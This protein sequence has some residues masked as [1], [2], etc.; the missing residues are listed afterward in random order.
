MDATHV[1]SCGPTIGLTTS[2]YVQ[3]C[4]ALQLPN[5]KSS[6]GSKGKVNFLVAAIGNPSNLKTQHT[7]VRNG[8]Q[9]L[10]CEHQPQFKYGQKWTEV[11]P[12]WDVEKT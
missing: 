10:K 3:I 11:K 2:N 6:T 4:I 5:P 9:A 8:V 12:Q 1:N 7:N